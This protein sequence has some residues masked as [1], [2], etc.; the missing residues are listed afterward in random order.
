MSMFVQ[1]AFILCLWCGG[2]VTNAQDNATTATS[3][4]TTPGPTLS[5]QGTEADDDVS[6][7]GLIVGCVIAG[8]IVVIVCVVVYV[9][10]WRQR[11][12]QRQLNQNQNAKVVSA[13]YLSAAAASYDNDYEEETLEIPPR[14]VSSTSTPPT[15]PPEKVPRI[16]TTP[17]GSLRSVSSTSSLSTEKGVYHIYDDF[18]VETL[19]IPP[20]K[21][22]RKPNPPTGLGYEADD[23]EK[24]HLTHSGSLSVAVPHGDRRCAAFHVP[25]RKV[26]RIPNPPTVPPSEVSGILIVRSGDRRC[27]AFHVPPKKVPRIPTPPT[28]VDYY[29]DVYFESGWHHEGVITIVGGAVKLDD[30]ILTIGAGCLAE[31]TEI[32][33]KNGEQHF[34]FTSL[35]D[36]VR[37]T[38]RVVEFLPNGL[39]FLK[40]AELTIRPMRV[41]VLD[42]ELFVLHG[43]HSDIYDKVVWELLSSGISGINEKK[44]G[45]INVE[46]YGFCFFSYILARRGRLARILSHLNHSFTCRA[47]VLH[48]RRPANTMDI[49]VVIVSEF[50]DDGEE[51]DIR[52][53]KDHI[54]EGYERGEKGRLT[55]VHTN[56]RLVMS[57]VILGVETNPYRFK[58]DRSQLDSVG[59][60][61][62]HFRGIA[63][64]QRENKTVKISEACED[65][66]C[67]WE[68]DVHGAVQIAHED[69][70]GQPETSGSQ[71]QG[72][73]RTT[74][75]TDEEVGKM[76]REVGI[77]WDG[78]G[79]LMDIP[80]E[81]REEIKLNVANYPKFSSRAGQI[82]THFNK[83]EDFCRH[84]VR[85]CLEELGRHDVKE[86][87]LPL[88]DETEGGSAEITNSQPEDPET[89][90]LQ[91]TPLS[92]REMFRLS[93]RIAVHWD[94]LASLIG[95]KS[96]ERDEIRYNYFVYQDNCAKAEKILS[97]FNRGENFSRKTLADFLNEIGQDEWVEPILTG[98]WRIL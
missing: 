43:Y 52:Q 12:R 72:V 24:P 71:P 98:K 81:K 78:L 91:N 39:K 6:R 53:L 5:T 60:S 49:V 69:V 22:P 47:Y 61:V 50:V 28:G 37:D 34:D 55:R 4:M 30:F 79:G 94:R 8:V 88:D 68:L 58:I 51:G 56:R 23:L 77:D 84:A 86:K 40:P 25:P 44:I 26:P 70:Y 41:E 20:R 32:T 85:K 36:L 42:L 18:E 27:A 10:C 95:I 75:L 54:G 57:L 64:E 65:G 87:M 13:V 76:R 92:P 14:K 46:I 9:V 83:S 66:E 33:L 19:A 62:N 45:T 80:Y 97:I 48:R 90:E 59:F 67:L 74:K 89:D 15:V 29:E 93:Q 11:Q 38:P 1:I 31:D 2:L 21:V 96:A 17:T 73:Q 3:V 35:K 7:L 82:L 63:S 16:S